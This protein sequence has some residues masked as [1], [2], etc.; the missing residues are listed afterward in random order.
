MAKGHYAKFTYE[1][2]DARINADAVRQVFGDALDMMPVLKA[3]KYKGGFKATMIKKVCTYGGATPNGD[4]AKPGDTP[5][6]WV[7]PRIIS[8][9]LGP[10]L[11]SG[12]I[13][14]LINRQ[15]HLYSGSLGVFADDGRGTIQKF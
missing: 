2:I 4:I 7:I 6:I 9:N 15:L 14:D 5:Q 10:T 11:H 3:G 1:I 12:D 8:S 13:A